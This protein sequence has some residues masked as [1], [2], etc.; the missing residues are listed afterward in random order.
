MT[1]IIHW[2]FNW[3]MDP[4]SGC[5]MA[6]DI[7]LVFTLPPRDCS[8]KDAYTSEIT[9]LALLP[10]M[11]SPFFEHGPIFFLSNF[12]SKIKLIWLGVHALCSVKLYWNNFRF[13]VINLQGVQTNMSAEKRLIN[14]LLA[15]SYQNLIKKLL[16]L[17]Q[18][19]LY[20]LCSYD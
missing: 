1:R 20:P 6:A 2:F 16:S 17:S 8:T 4:M 15:I 5:D 9:F 13:S 11:E 10:C 14:T 3:K 7:C 12:F 19:F 18:P